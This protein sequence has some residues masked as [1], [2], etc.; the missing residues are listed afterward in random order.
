MDISEPQ[1]D[2]KSQKETIGDIVWRGYAMSEISRLKGIDPDDI[3]T[4]DVPC[5]KEFT[6]EEEKITHR[7]YIF[8]QND[9]ATLFDFSFWEGD[10]RP[11]IQKGII[12]IE[13]APFLEDDFSALFELE[14]IA[15]S[16]SPEKSKISI[17][18]SKKENTLEISMPEPEKA[19]DKDTTDDE[20]TGN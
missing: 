15:S 10:D 7:V 20:S 19:L 12:P 6:Q 1:N 3:S 14:A 11:P 18:Y 2:Q 5:F 17:R 8:S 13:K 4:F 9:G 16:N